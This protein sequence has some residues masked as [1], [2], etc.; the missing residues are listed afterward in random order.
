MLDQARRVREDHGVS[1]VGLS[2]GVFQNRVLTDL[3]VSQLQADEFSVVL[4]ERLPCNDAAL[5]FGQVAEFA[6]RQ[7]QETAVG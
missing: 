1:R 6:A 4:A 5:S 3:A 2:G 7:T